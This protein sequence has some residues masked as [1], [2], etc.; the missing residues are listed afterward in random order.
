MKTIEFTSNYSAFKYRM[1]AEVGENLT[2]A[3]EALCMEGIANICYRTAGSNVD[4]ALGVKSKKN[5][6]MGRE[7][8][9]YD[10]ALGETI[11]AAVSAKITELENATG[12]KVKALKL[13]FAV[14][15]EHV[16]GESGDAP[17]KEATEMWTKVQALVETP[18]EIAGGMAKGSKFEKALKTLG[19]AED[20]TDE[21]GIMACKARLTAA[22]QAAKVAAATALGM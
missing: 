21:Q 19:L 17:T 18:E 20:Y 14:I 4:K 11:N 16:K 7:G 9:S 6:G 15:G 12:S 10:S 8:L 1:T 2:E 5:G 3:T 13:S 22:K